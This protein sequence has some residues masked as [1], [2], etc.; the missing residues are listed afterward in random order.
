[1]E[2]RKYY[3]KFSIEVIAFERMDVL[4]VSVS[5]NMKPEGDYDDG[6]DWNE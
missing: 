2:K 4:T 5:N 1:M 6:K 3:E